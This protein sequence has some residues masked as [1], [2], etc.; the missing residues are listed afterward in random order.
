MVHNKQMYRVGDFVYVEPKE[1]GMD[2][3]I[4]L[5]DRMWTAE[6]GKQML[7]GNFFYRPNETYHVATRKF[8][9]QVSLLGFTAN[10]ERIF[11]NHCSLPFLFVLFFVGSF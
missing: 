2:P 7:Y 9:E 6:D 8:L 11:G 10:E 5:I 3:S 1:R 4:L